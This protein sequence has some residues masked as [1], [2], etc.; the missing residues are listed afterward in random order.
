VRE[1]GREKKEMRMS[2]ARTATGNRQA[3]ALQRQTSVLY[4]LQE[5]HEKENLETRNARLMVRTEC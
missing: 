2:S 3:P 4:D 5:T 1:R